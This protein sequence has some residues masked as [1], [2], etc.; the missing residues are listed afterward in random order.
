MKRGFVYIMANKYNTVLYTGVT[1][2]LCGRVHKHK[3]GEGSGFTI[4]YKTTKL[5]WYDEYPRMRDAIEAEKKIKKWKRKWKLEL[6]EELN[7]KFEDLYGDI[8]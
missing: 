8:C 6:I 2:D 5:V 3:S 7:P 4:K 1:G